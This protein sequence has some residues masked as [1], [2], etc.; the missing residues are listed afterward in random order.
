MAG[1]QGLPLLSIGK[2]LEL[3]QASFCPQAA[4]FGVPAAGPACVPAVV[5]LS[6]LFSR[7]STAAPV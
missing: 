6:D 3:P 7:G 5:G 4:N 1:H 2:F